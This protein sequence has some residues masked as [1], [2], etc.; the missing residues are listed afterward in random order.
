MS[1]IIDIFIRT[2]DEGQFKSVVNTSSWTIRQPGPEG[3]VS[4]TL[5]KEV[6]SCGAFIPSQKDV[7][8]VHQA[9]TD[10]RKIPAAPQNITS[11]PQELPAPSG[12]GMVL[13][14]KE[15][16]EVGYLIFKASC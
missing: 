13:T 7:S 9:D 5:P 11:L 3:V 14:D 12:S 8:P 6:Q 10:L 2:T 15:K 4:T 16:F 1:S